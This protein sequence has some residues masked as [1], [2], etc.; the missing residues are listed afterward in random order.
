MRIDYQQWIK[1][2]NSGQEK[3]RPQQVI[4]ELELSI[5]QIEQI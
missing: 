4:F 2:I 5:W 3:A 1:L